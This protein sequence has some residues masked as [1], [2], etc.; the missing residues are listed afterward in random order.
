MG[1]ARGQDVASVAVLLGWLSAP[2]PVDPG[3]LLDPAESALPGLLAQ[4]TAD[5]ARLLQQR[6]PLGVQVPFAV[7]VA[8]LAAQTYARRWATNEVPA[9]RLPCGVS[10][11]AQ[12][13]AVLRQAAAGGGRAGQ[14]P[15]AFAGQLALQVAPVDLLELVRRCPPGRPDLASGPPPGPSR[16]LPA[17]VRGVLLVAA[18]AGCAVAGFAAAVAGFAAWG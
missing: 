15:A 2:P 14:P 7:A 10:A 3:L 1:G 5:D 13:L 9:V 18:L 16:R 4:V 17:R 11:S 12:G 8:A 6:S